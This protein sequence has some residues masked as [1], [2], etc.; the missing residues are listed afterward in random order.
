M[1]AFRLPRYVCG[2]WSLVAQ[3]RIG[4]LIGNETGEHWC[5]VSVVSTGKSGTPVA[6]PFA[7]L[8]EIR[9]SVLKTKIADV[10]TSAKS[11]VQASMIA[12]RDLLGSSPES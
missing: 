6:A 8:H 7:S 4:G 5:A 3:S 1:V 12:F 10:P 11:F 9:S 2:F